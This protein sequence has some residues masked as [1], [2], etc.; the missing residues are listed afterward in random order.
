MQWHVHRENSKEVAGQSV[1]HIHLHFE[2]EMSFG[3]GGMRQNN[4]GEGKMEARQVFQL[5]IIT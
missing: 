5:E 1:K 4:Q 3:D 2:S